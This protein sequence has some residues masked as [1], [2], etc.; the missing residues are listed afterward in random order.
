M[1]IDVHAHLG[2]DYTFD[3]DATREELIDKKDN[4]NIDVQI[5]QP[6][7]CH[8]LATVKEQHNKIAELCKSFPGRFF[9]MANP[10]PHLPTA[11]YNDEI[12][13]CVEELGF[14][15][16]KLNPQASGV[17]PGSKSGRNCFDAAQKHGIPIMV[18]T[19]DGG[20][21][22]DPIKLL[23]IAKEYSEVKIIMAH[24]GMLVL[25]GNASI[26]FAACRN[27]YGDS[28]WTPGF[29]IKDWMKAYGPRFMFGTDMA[30]NSRVEL[31]KMQ[32]SDFSEDELNSILWE[33][34]AEVFNLKD[35]LPS[36]KQ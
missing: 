34:A 14:T 30:V 18:H 15:S 16:I 27:V 2:K 32:N 19:G 21:F 17:N 7:Q 10:S 1:I 4:L 13:R 29:V 8:D 24:C 31:A 9:G 33:T 25:A 35:R 6:G 23:D 26:V 28:T 22:A 3:E 36:S 5:I 11:K 12:T 20:S